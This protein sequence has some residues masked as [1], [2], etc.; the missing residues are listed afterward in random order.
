MVIHEKSAMKKT[1]LTLHD[2]SE[3]FLTEKI[4]FILTRFNFSQKED[5]DDLDILVK[6]ASFQR[7]ISA[8]E[9]RGYEV[10]SH[11]NVLG[12]RIP[13]MQVNLIKKG[14]VK[15]DL[16]RDFTWRKFRYLDLDIVWNDAR[17]VEVSNTSVLI[18]L[19]EIDAFLIMINVIFEKTYLTKEEVDIFWYQRE[20]ISKI[21]MF[22]QQAVKY[23]WGGTFLKF[24]GWVGGQ[25]EPR[26]F[27]LF[28][29]FFLV[30]YSYLEKFSLVSFLYYC[31]FR[32]RFL[33]NSKL[34]YD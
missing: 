15:I 19:A 10:H 9:K 1:T 24:Q 17:H 34:P 27:P 23:G 11:D 32:V 8:L 16:H 26:N 33:L 20:K 29:P 4:D 22:Y 21:P 25:N 5:P 28:L 18:P 2:L 7:A 6:L 12:G 3:T 13:G 30:L 14:R 31:F